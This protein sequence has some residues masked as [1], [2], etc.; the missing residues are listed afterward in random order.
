[1]VC[2]IGMEIIYTLVSGVIFQG[3]LQLGEVDCFGCDGEVGSFLSQAICPAR[4]RRQLLWVVD[5]ALFVY[6]NIENFQ[7]RQACET[8]DDRIITFLVIEIIAWLFML[9]TVGRG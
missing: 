5:L 2:L 4:L 7:V 6:I 1:M 8:L 9:D 3:R